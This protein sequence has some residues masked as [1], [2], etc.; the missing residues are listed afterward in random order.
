MSMPIY[1][2]IIVYEDG[3]TETV[4]S[5]YPPDYSDISGDAHDV[6]AMIRNGYG[7]YEVSE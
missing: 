4:S 1:S 5:E 3:H 7:G 6:V 2:W